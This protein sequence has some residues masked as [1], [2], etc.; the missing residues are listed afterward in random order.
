MDPHS[1]RIDRGEEAAY[2]ISR[3]ARG[4]I[5]QVEAWVGPHQLVVVVPPGGWHFHEPYCP[6]AGMMEHAQYMPLTRALRQRLSRCQLCWPLHRDGDG[7]PLGPRRRGTGALLPGG[8]RHGAV[9][10]IPLSIRIPRL[11]SLRVRLSAPSPCDYAA[12][13]QLLTTFL[14]AAMPHFTLAGLDVVPRSGLQM[15]GPE[16]LGWPELLRAAR[17]LLA[18][19]SAVA[20]EQRPTG[21]AAE[22]TLRGEHAPRHGGLVPPALPTRWLLLLDGGDAEAHPAT[23]A[24]AQRAAGAWSANSAPSLMRFSTLE[25]Q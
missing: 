3:R 4:G 5:R 7:P 20:L 10:P 23:P 25:P 17:C 9:M 19:D 2:L 11:P 21:T 16:R 24:W 6:R 15:V 22:L 1:T 13:W 14:L 18:R 12:E 8:S